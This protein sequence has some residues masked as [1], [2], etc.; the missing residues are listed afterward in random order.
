M[1]RTIFFKNQPRI[2]GTS[3]VAGPKECAGSIKEYIQTK[4]E[5]DDYGEKSFEKAEKGILKEPPRS[6]QESIFNKED[7]AK[8]TAQ[9]N[10]IHKKKWRY[11]NNSCSHPAIIPGSIMPKAIK[12]V[13][14]A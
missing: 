12:A 6:P 4:L 11:P 10:I 9:H 7:T 13:Q 2:I 8:V 1:T 14:I 5:N 3:S